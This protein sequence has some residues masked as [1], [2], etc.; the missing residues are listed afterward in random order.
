LCWQPED[1]GREFTVTYYTLDNTISI[2]EPPKR[3]SGIIGG[4]F[5]SRREIKD[6]NNENMPRV[7]WRDAHRRGPGYT[8]PWAFPNHN[9]LSSSEIG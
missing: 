6:I 7:R 3:N 8:R 4:K 1:E 9:K 2:Y 5:L